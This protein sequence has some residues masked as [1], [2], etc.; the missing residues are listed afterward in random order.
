MLNKIFKSITVALPILALGLLGLS[1]VSLGDHRNRVDC[2]DG[3][4]LQRAVDRARRGAVINVKGTCNERITITTDNLTLDGG[5]SAVIDGD[6]P[7]PVGDTTSLVTIRATNVTIKG[8]T[9][10]DGPGNGVSVGRS[11]SAIIENNTIQRHARSGILIT[12]GSYAGVGDASGATPHPTPG[13]RGNTI[14][15]NG[16]H[17]VVINTNGSADIYHNVIDENG[18]AGIQLNVG[19]AADIDANEITDND[20][21]GIRLRQNASVRLDD[22]RRH[23]EAGDDPNAINGNERGIDCRTG[24]SLEGNPPDFTGGNTLANRNQDGSCVERVTGFAFP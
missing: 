6:T 22:F 3:D 1:S 18:G 17:G 9:I 5:G 8:F 16:N 4:S 13:D 24:A 10:Q 15:D 7:S 14:F 2:D 21:A 20:R 23:G 19:S 11:G 12:N